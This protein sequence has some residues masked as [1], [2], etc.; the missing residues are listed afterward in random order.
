MKISLKKTIINKVVIDIFLKLKFNI[1]KNYMNFKM[2][3]R[4][5]KKEVKIKKVEKLVANLLDKREYIINIT[6]LK[7]VLNHGLVLK[8]YIEFLNS[9]KMFGQNHI[10]T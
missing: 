10:L 7:Q 3:Y 6:N 5:Y 9:I 4:F 1:L 8:N 2:I